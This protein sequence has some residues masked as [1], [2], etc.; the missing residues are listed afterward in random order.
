M[1]DAEYD[2]MDAAE[3]TMWWYRA[4]HRRLVG[5]LTDVTGS[6]LDAGCGTGGVLARLMAERPDLW[7]CGV[8]LFPSAA[9]RA[10]AKSGAPTVC[11]SVQALPFADGVFDAVLSADVLCHKALEPDAAL[12]EM[13]RVLRPGG[14]LVINLPAYNWLMSA[15]DHRV[16]NARRY[17]ASGLRKLLN[18]SG[19]EMVRTTY[20]NTLLLPLMI[21]ERK[22]L[23]RSPSAAS[24]VKPF[25]PPIDALLFAATEIERRVPLPMPAGGS[26][27]AVARRT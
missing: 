22:L 8:D 20:W 1:E 2:L 13:A 10:A 3:T 9:A 15:H 21:I 7:S 17:T 4:L 19:F 27:L 24:D 23:A 16:H 25:S 12:V 18:A 11:A 14:R 26:V 5:A 6:I